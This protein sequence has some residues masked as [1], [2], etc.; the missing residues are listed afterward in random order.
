MLCCN[1]SGLVAALHSTRC[2]M[3]RAA[4]EQIG[5]TQMTTHIPPPP[6]P[7]FTLKRYHSLRSILHAFCINVDEEEPGIYGGPQT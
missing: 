3:Q 2:A 6:L 4:Q 5:R 7:L 1:M